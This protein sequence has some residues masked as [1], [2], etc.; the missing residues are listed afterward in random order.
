M[1]GQIWQLHRCFWRLM[2]S[3][4]KTQDTGDCM[5]VVNM[6]A[7][8]CKHMYIYTAD[9]RSINARLVCQ[10]CSTQRVHTFSLFWSGCHLAAGGRLGESWWSWGARLI[11][12]LVWTT[13]SSSSR[14][15]S[16]PKSGSQDPEPSFPN[17]CMNISLSN[18]FLNSGTKGK[19]I[20][21]CKPSRSWEMR[22]WRFAI[23]WSFGLQHFT[24]CRRHISGCFCF[25]NVFVGFLHKDRK[26]PLHMVYIYSS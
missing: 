11:P 8:M 17:P 1:H 5:Q 12:H 25:A 6:H 3:Q 21:F 14:C 19:N 9:V 23:W 10:T 16:V 22:S 2:K 18:Q 7:H 15:C 13:C 20:A 26:Y 4:F 24:M